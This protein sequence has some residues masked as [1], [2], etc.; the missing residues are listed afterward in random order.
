MG[1]LT[2]RAKGRKRFRRIRPE[3]KFLNILLL[4]IAAALIVLGVSRLGSED[5]ADSTEVLAKHVEQPS[6][7]TS[8]PHRAPSTTKTTATTAAHAAAT[9]ATTAPD[10]TTKHKPR[11]RTTSSTTGAHASSTSRSPSG[12]FVSVPPV[13]GAQ[14]S[15]PPATHPTTTTTRAPVTTTTT[16]AP[17][18]TTTTSPM[19]PPPTIPIPL[20]DPLP[21]PG[22]PIP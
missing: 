18:T 15:P 3:D 4:V 1:K 6:T 7:T 22:L 20:P 10:A 21:L 8:K 5:R 14:G 13:Q 16:H 9:T 2:R 19:L 17:P 12:T 11:H